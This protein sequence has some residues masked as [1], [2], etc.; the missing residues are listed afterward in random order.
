MDDP[1]A[2]EGTG[3]PETRLDIDTFSTHPDY[4][5][6]WHLFLRGLAVVMT[7][8]PEN[9]I[10]FYRIAGIYAPVL[11]SIYRSRMGTDIIKGSMVGQSSPGRNSRYSQGRQFIARI[12]SKIDYYLHPLYVGFFWRYGLTSIVFGF[13]LGIG[14]TFSFWRSALP[15]LRYEISRQSLT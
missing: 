15:P 12:R 13:L 7:E 3:A 10:G 5:I 2:I 1:Y 9:P 14:L 11:C 6:R 4:K 8:P